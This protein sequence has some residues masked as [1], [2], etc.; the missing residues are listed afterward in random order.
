MRCGAFDWGPGEMLIHRQHAPLA[1]RQDAGR[2]AEHRRTGGHRPGHYG[3]H[4]DHRA[5]TDHERGIVRAWPQYGAGTDIG[6]VLDKDTAVTLYSWSKSDKI[7]DYAI[8]GD[9][10][11]QIAVKKAAN[12]RI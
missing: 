11:I 12:G 5:P 1:L 3:T 10:R 6:V 9:V 4:A 7:T 8:M 2:I